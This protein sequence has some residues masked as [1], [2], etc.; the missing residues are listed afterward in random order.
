MKVSPSPTVSQ[1]MSTQPTERDAGVHMA[2]AKESKGIKI[3]KTLWD[4]ALSSSVVYLNVI[5][6]GYCCFF[7]LHSTFSNFKSV[8]TTQENIIENFRKCICWLL[9]LSFQS[10]GK[11]TLT[12]YKLQ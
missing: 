7:W 2:V 9:N 8:A 5:L 10:K 4:L 11:I 3:M 6:H 12:N 1:N